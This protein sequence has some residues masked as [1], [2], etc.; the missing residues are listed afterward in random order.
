MTD[1]LADSVA[2][3]HR[4]YG[5]RQ[6]RPLKNARAEA[7]SQLAASQVP[8]GED[9]LDPVNLLPSTVKKYWLEIGFG[10]GEHMIG[11]LQNNPDIGFIGCEPFVNGVSAALKDAAAVEVIDRLRVHAD[12][13]RALLPRLPTASI[14]RGFVLFSD[15]WPKTRHHRRRFIQSE[16]LDM[17]A[18]LLR[19]GAELRLAT[20]DPGL[21]GWSVEQI[22]THPAFDWRAN[23][24]KDWQTAPEDWV[25]TRYQIK[26]LEQGR[27]SFY[28][29][30]WR[31]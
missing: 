5:R 17:L 14:D 27:P 24:M 3:P 2:F 8:P 12:D 13:A 31:V 16:T 30:S 20:D 28:L 21:A 6:G 9:L 23:S 4:F 7:L 29:R 1:N 25:P 22:H 11:Q 15:P 18:R 19:S 10:N 26:A